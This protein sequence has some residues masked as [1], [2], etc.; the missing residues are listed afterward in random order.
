MVCIRKDYPGDHARQRHLMFIK[1]NW[2][3][4]A[5]AAYKG[6]LE[7]GRG[8]VV[9]DSDSFVDMPVGVTVRFNVAYVSEGS[10]AL[11]KMK[12]W[13][14]NKESSWVKQYD[15]SSTMLVGFCRQDGGFSSY[16]IQGLGGGIPEQIY[17]QYNG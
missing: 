5:M 9:V 3:L 7:S 10:D 4:L 6:Y 2:D 8:M 12:G 13:P 11:K 14:G 15:P 16:R 1:A 17:K